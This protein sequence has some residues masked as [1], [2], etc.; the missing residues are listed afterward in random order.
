MPDDIV[1]GK[2]EMAKMP[3]K[4]FQALEAE[5][6][7]SEEELMVYPSHPRNMLRFLRLNRVVV[8]GLL[9]CRGCV[10]SVLCMF[11]LPYSVYDFIQVSA[12]GVFE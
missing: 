2:A 6:L 10:S 9:C 5:R 3:R 11:C 8:K 1:H 4:L 7:T 12:V